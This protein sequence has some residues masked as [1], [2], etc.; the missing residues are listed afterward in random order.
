MLEPLLQLIP[1][2]FDRVQFG[3]FRG[4]VPHFEVVPAYARDRTV[5]DSFGLA[6]S[7][8]VLP[9]IL[10]IEVA[11]SVQNTTDSSPNCSVNASNSPIP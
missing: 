10:R 7:T 2:P 8:D 11:R 5:S 3:E 1:A 9:E 4:E 6:L